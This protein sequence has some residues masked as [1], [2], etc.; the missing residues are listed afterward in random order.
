MDEINSSKD[1]RRFQRVIFDAP[2]NLSFNN[3]SYEAHLVDISLKGAL[4][5]VPEDLQIKVGAQIELTV[6][7]DDA[8][9]DIHMQV[10]AAHTA[11]GQIGFICAT[12]D[13]ESITHLRRLVELNVG[14]SSLLERELQALG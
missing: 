12:I 8:D 5:K 4:V 7:L 6:D 9:T 2:V 13:M 10:R 1:R 14:D 11:A 3:L